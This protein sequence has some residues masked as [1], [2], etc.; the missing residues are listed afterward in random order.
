MSQSKALKQHLAC[1]KHLVHARSYYLSPNQPGLKT[2]PAF[3]T[4]SVKE[5]P[6]LP[7]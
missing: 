4:S 2:N 1:R 3:L 5:G 6:S 7:F